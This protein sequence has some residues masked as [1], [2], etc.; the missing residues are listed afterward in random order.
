[1]AYT[2]LFVDGIYITSDTFDVSFPRGA[3]GSFIKM[4]SGR[5]LKASGFGKTTAS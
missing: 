4:L 2:D 5:V 1:M 3:F